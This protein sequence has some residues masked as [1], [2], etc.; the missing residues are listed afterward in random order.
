MVGQMTQNQDEK[1]V[2]L[3]ELH[4]LI[5][6]SSY[7]SAEEKKRWDTYKNLFSLSILSEMKSLLI[8]LELGTITT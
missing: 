3:G 5:H 1:E 8:S 6:K 4:E 7:L 2:L